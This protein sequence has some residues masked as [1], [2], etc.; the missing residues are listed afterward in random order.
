MKRSEILSSLKDAHTAH[1]KWVEYG[2][3]LLEKEGEEKYQAP[4]DC[5]ECN[6]G[7][8]FYA[9]WIFIKNIPGFK[10]IESLHENFHNSY[11]K[12]YSLAPEAH[13]P[14][15]FLES[16][17]VKEEQRKVLLKN[18]NHLEDLSIRLTKVLKSIETVVTAMS[19]KLFERNMN[20]S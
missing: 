16:K 19:D 8:W 4:L 14:K 5:T 20:I 11:D 15:G 1:T 9:K 3:L 12:L 7:Q 6:F 2:R 18:F 10:E 17:K 13:K